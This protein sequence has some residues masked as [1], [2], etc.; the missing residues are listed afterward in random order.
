MAST[1]DRGTPATSAWRCQCV[2]MSSGAE[3][4]WHSQLENQREGADRDGGSSHWCCCLPGTDAGIA[5]SNDPSFAL[6]LDGG[7]LSAGGFGGGTR[8]AVGF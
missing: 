4:S 8:L 2:L 7:A 5:C 1:A 3:W 6:P